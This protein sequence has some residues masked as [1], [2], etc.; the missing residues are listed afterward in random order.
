LTLAIRGADNYEA[1]FFALCDY[2]AEHRVLWSTLLNGGAGAAMRE[3]WLHQSRIVAAAETP[4]N[5]W[6]PPALGT[7]CA[8]TLIAETL[9]W[10][11]GQPEKAYSPEEI[12]RILHRLLTTSIMAPD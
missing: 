12:A 11:V 2:V 1:G 6:L 4:I 3:E 9:A 8:A 5:S 7:I 10:W